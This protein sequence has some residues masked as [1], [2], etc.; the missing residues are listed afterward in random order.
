VLEP[1]FIDRSLGDMAGVV[2][3]PPDADAG[4]GALYANDSLIVFIHLHDD[5]L[6]LVAP[7][8]YCDELESEDFRTD[9]TDAA[10]F[11]REEADHFSYFLAANRCAGASR[12]LCVSHD[13]D[14]N[15]VLLNCKALY[16]VLTP[17]RLRALIRSLF[18]VVVA[19]RLERFPD[20][21]DPELAQLWNEQ[22]QTGPA[23]VEPRPDAA[24]G[25][26]P[27]QQV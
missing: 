18:G 22:P 5:H 8:I 9:V 17:A 26:Q 16:A 3:Q 10:D 7:I 4:V 2:Y 15:A 20:E 1:D 14:S 21:V 19:M 11:Y 27:S 12:G 25:L 6:R 24:H 23:A 13:Q